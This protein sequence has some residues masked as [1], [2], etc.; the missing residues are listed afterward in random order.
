[1]NIQDDG[2]T[3]YWTN[4][5]QVSTP[6]NSTRTGEWPP[7]EASKSYESI[8]TNLPGNK[9]WPITAF[10]ATALSLAIGGVLFPMVAGPIFRTLL[11]FVYRNRIWGRVIIAPLPLA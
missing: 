2:L 10:I 4:T 6:A 11:R 5:T 7:P 9:A 1:M 3:M 8:H